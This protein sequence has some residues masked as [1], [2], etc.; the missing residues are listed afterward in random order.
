MAI[1]GILCN[2]APTWMGVTLP[3]IEEDTN[4]TSMIIFAF[5]FHP[6][7]IFFPYLSSKSYTFGK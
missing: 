7:I 3:K 2:E 5:E 1:T 6:F 4:L